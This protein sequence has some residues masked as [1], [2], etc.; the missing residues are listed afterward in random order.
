M[1]VSLHTRH[2]FGLIIQ[3]NP[4]SLPAEFTETMITKQRNGEFEGVKKPE[5]NKYNKKK[6]NLITN[7]HES[8]GDGEC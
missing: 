6:S 7:L 2:K 1:R 3:T 4:N 8:L 5:Q